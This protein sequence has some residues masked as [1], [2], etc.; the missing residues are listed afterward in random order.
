MDY[1][2]PSSAQPVDYKER[3]IVLTSDQREDGAWGCQYSITEEGQT[4]PKPGPG[5]SEVSFPSREAAEL[6]ALQKAKTVIDLRTVS[7]S[8]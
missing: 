2:K 4:Q 5:Q 7:D 6:A 3:Q 8:P 1:D